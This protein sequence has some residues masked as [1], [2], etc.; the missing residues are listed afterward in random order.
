MLVRASGVGGAEIGPWAAMG[1]ATEMGLCAS[2]RSREDAEFPRNDGA[3][4]ARGQ[5]VV[6]ITGLLGRTYCYGK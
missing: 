4:A 5:S 1:T 2:G 3:R 6:E